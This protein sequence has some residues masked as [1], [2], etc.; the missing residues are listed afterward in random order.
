MNRKYFIP[1]LIIVVSIFSACQNSVADSENPSPT[2]SQTPLP[3]QTP[4]INSPIRKIDFKNFKYPNAGD[5]AGFK[6]RNGEK[7][8]I[9][10]KEAGIDL[11]KIEYTDVTNDGEEDAIIFMSIQTGGSSMPNIIYIYTLQ[12]NKPKLLWG[13]LT[14][15]RA[16]GGLKKIYKENDELI[17]ELFGDSKFINDKWKF[18]SDYEKY[19]GDGCLTIYTR[20]RFKWN[21]QKFV[22]VGSPEIF[23]FPD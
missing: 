7:P 23:D 18:N 19:C 20:N 21:G 1:L 9:H 17:V 22:V 4:E 13:F 2:V 12:K 11:Y 10:Q 5:Y 8:Y 3:T 6:L 14:G 15:D 16:V